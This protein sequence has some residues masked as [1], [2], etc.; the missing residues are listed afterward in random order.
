MVVWFGVVRLQ[1]AIKQSISRLINQRTG[2]EFH[3]F[4]LARMVV[5]SWAAEEGS[6]GIVYILL[7]YSRNIVKGCM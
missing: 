4:F 3:L 2:G 1:S 7:P 6:E 5:E